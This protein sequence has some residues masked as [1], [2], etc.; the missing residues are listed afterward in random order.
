M[1]RTIRVTGR[2]RISV[3]PD[4]TVISLGFS[5]TFTSYEATLEASAKEVSMV[6]DML[7][8]LGFDREGLKTTSFRIEPEYESYKD[9]K[10][11]YRSEFKGYSYSQRLRFTFPTSNETLGRVLYTVAHSG[12]D[13]RVN[14]SFTNSDPEGAKL[15]LIAEAVKDSRRKAEIIADAAGVVLGEIEN[16][17]Y[18]WSTMVFESRPID[19]CYLEAAAMYSV[20]IEPE[21]I[22]KEDDITIVWSI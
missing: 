18:S 16:I 4:I 10:G 2:G 7:T 9:S 1:S 14:I 21:D 13:P 8:D 22:E 3:K 12:I 6:K 19:E 11:N 15:K 17:D 20:D 5:N